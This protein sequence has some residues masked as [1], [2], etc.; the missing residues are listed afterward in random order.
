MK[1]SLQVVDESGDPPPAEP[2]RV[3]IG[4]HRVSVI[5]TGN[6]TSS[7]R[8][9]EGLIEAGAI[10]VDS[11]VAAEP[12]TRVV[13]RCTPRSAEARLRAE[14]IER[15]ADLVLGSARPVFA[16]LFASACARWVNS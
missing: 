9:V 14:G 6:G 11:P 5:D 8:F 13:I 1:R 16:R 3:T 4:D 10:R 7:L 12:A 2:V 15:A